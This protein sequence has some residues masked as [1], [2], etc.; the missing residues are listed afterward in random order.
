[1]N[2]MTFVTPA[3]MLATMLWP[4][5]SQADILID[6]TTNNGSFELLGG[7]PSTAKATHWDTDPDG[8]VDNW[9]VW[10][11]TVGGPSTA[12]ND[13]GTDLGNAPTDGTHV[14][15]LQPGNAAYNLTSHI[16]QVGDVFTYSWDWTLAGRGNA[17]AGLAYFD[18]LNV[19]AIPSTETTNPDTAQ[20]WNGLGTTYTALA[21]D[22]A[23]GNAMALTVVS[24]GNWPEVDN[25]V[26]TVIPEPSTLA[27]FGGVGMLLVLMRRRFDS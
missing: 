11:A 18:G 3:L 5:G 27:L 9:S 25:F 22:P 17:T 24:G 14:A 21:G 7:A 10:G 13:S 8:N 1:M 19:V 23:I 2:K 16:V 15:F 6:A 20:P 12:E 26:L 4:L